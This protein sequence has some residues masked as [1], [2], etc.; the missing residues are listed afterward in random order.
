MGTDGDLETASRPTTAVDWTGANDEAN[1]Q[2]WTLSK[3]LYHTFIPTSI[4][5]LCPFGSSVYTPGHKQVM[6]EFNVSREIALLPF[7]FY[8]LGLSFGP[9]LAAPVSET[10]GRKV[11][12][13]SALPVFAAF[14]IGAGFSNNITALIFCRFFA[15]LFSSP[16]LS[17]GTG[18]ISDIWPPE[19][20]GAPMAT[21]VTSVQMGPAL[22]PCIGGFVVEKRGWRWTQWTILFGLVIV[23]TTT[24]GMSE[25]YKKCILQSRAKKLG[26]PGPP[27]PQRSKKE[28]IKFFATKTVARPMHMLF[29]EP[30]VTLFDAY[31]AFNFGLLNAF[32][33]AFTWVFENVYGFDVASAGLTYLGQAAGSLVG[34]AIM[35]Y[36]YHFIWAKESQRIKQEEGKSAKMAPEKRLIIAKLGAPLLPISL[37]SIS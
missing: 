32:F 25:T 5:F 16:G 12:Y 33:A 14:T 24:L 4:A 6:A 7:V 36:V 9:V 19:K 21:F 10:F 3:K 8:L 18:T 2:H 31:V 28:T 15:G 34:L 22:G 20:R 35:L 11:V 27:E 30:I 1:P 13:I 17:I 37:V 26:I 29:T 23:L